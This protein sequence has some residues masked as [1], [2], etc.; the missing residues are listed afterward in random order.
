MVND[1]NIICHNHLM[2]GELN[3]E[4][5]LYHL[6]DSTILVTNAEYSI[7]RK[8]YV[9]VLNFLSGGEIDGM[10]NYLSIFFWHSSEFNSKHILSILPKTKVN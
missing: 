6:M 9:G 4:Q 3:T 8:L 7:E 10:P 5:Y 1:C 2:D